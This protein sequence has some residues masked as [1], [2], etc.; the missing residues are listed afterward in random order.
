MRGISIAV[1]ITLAAG[2]G[3]PA[4]RVEIAEPVDII[5]RDDYASK[6]AGLRATL[7]R[8]GIEIDS[9]PV[10]E[11]CT[12]S[13]TKGRC[14]R[15]ELATRERTSGLD[16]DLLDAVSIAFGRYPP[17]TLAKANILHVALCRSIRFSDSTDDG[18]A[19][20]AMLGDRRILVSVEHFIGDREYSSFTIEQV[21]H[22]EVFHMLDPHLDDDKEWKAL[23]P[24]G[25]AY[26]GGTGSSATA[27]RGFVNEYA[28]ASDAEDRASTFEYLMSQPKKLCELAAKDPVL[29]KKVKVVWKRVAPVLG[30]RH[31]QQWAPC[32]KR[33]VK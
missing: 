5:A 2:C 26:Q 8:S 20:L 4:Q 23:N 9:Q 33:L 14:V 19:G 22:H 31:L 29:A 15:C 28:T 25:F 6:I 24:R 16:S 10:I 7:A 30:E 12:G 21:V 3:Q 11:T 27:P 13:D 1:A 32:A 18:T 17:G